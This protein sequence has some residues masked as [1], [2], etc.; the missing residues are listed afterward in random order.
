[1]NGHVV[2]TP[3]QRDDG[4]VESAAGWGRVCRRRDRG[5][6][7]CARLSNYVCATIASVTQTNTHE[8]PQMSTPPANQVYT[9]IRTLCGGDESATDRLLDWITMLH[10]G[11]RPEQCLVLVGPA[12]CG[13]SNFV[14]VFLRALLD[15]LQAGHIYETTNPLHDYRRPGNGVIEQARLVHIIPSNFQCVLPTLRML[16]SHSTIRVRSIYDDERIVQSRHAF[17]VETNALPPLSV[18]DSRRFLCIQ[19]PPPPQDGW[20]GANQ[21][22]VDNGRD[23]G[24]TIRR[25]LGN[26]VLWARV[27]RKLRLRAIVVYWLYLTE[28]RMERGGVAFE[29]DHAEFDQWAVGVFAS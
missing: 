29:R 28:A 11:V 3:R 2:S 27:R 16:I 25:Y 9:Y 7:L 5:V 15:E 10:D 14:R 4:A 12:R 18:P 17:T 1:M 20:G 21:W 8:Q 23:L 22:L 19:C 6:R 26:R 24:R 13:K